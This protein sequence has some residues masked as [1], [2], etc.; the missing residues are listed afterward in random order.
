MGKSKYFSEEEIHDMLKPYAYKAFKDLA[1]ES[2]RVI[3]EF[4]R[5]Y[6]PEIYKRT[7]G[8][9][10][11]FSPKMKKIENGYYIEFTYSADFLTTEHRD[12]VAVFDGSFV[13][14]WH[15]GQY[16]W[17]NLKEYTPRTTPSPWRQLNR[18]VNGY[19]L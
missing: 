19:K 7:F 18:F 17:G 8:M 4:Y 14:G 16:A 12:D 3:D 9:K 5:D 1:N 2:Y 11:L 6:S 13:E 10:N 15:G